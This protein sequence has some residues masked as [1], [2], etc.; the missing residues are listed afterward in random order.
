MAI[1][2]THTLALHLHPPTGAQSPRTMLVHAT[3]PAIAEET[4]LAA[5]TAIAPD[6]RIAERVIIHLGTFREK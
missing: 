6:T 3:T 1:I 5:T 2:A 4:E